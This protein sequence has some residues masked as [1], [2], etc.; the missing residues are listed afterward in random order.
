S[1]FRILREQT[2]RMKDLMKHLKRGKVQNSLSDKAIVEAKETGA[3]LF[4]DMDTAKRKEK[5]EG[6]IKSLDEQL[7]MEMQNKELIEKECAKLEESDKLNSTPKH[8][9]E[10]KALEGKAVKSGEKLDAM[11]LLMLQYCSGLQTC[12]S[13]TDAMD[14]DQRKDVPQRPPPAGS[15]KYEPPKGARYTVTGFVRRAGT[16]VKEKVTSIKKDFGRKGKSTDKDGPS[17]SAGANNNK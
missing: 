1:R 11:R 8:R 3:R 5:L 17:T 16:S 13:A 6:L 14:T 15:P 9:A 4:L 10:L 2:D 12:L 7:I